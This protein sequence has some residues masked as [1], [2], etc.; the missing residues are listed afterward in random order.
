MVK[1]EQE[2]VKPWHPSCE[3]IKMLCS[4]YLIDRFNRLD[5]LIERHGNCQML[6]NKKH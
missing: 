1:V 2:S 6:N 3:S 4:S 5:R